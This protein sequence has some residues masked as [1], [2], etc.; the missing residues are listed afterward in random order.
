[1]TDT[2]RSE[3]DAALDQL[4]ELRHLHDPAQYDGPPSPLDGLP[5]VDADRFLADQDRLRSLVAA[6]LGWPAGAEWPTDPLWVYTGPS[7]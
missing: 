2:N 6:R 3:V 7:A 1:M 5:T 4:A